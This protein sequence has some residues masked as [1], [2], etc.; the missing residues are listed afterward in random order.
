K[1]SDA[2]Q[3]KIDHIKA[4]VS[5]EKNLCDH[6]EGFLNGFPPNLSATNGGN[7]KESL[8]RIPT[9]ERATNIQQR[10]PL[11]S[12]TRSMQ[13]LFEQEKMKYLQKKSQVSESSSSSSCDSTD[14]SDQRLNEVTDHGDG[15]CRQ[16]HVPSFSPAVVPPE[17]LMTHSSSRRK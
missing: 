1:S 4:T 2:S 6:L 3:T 10:I 15:N 9:G 7:R 8:L 5:N 13:Q 17:G 11:A 16:N 12:V 14:D